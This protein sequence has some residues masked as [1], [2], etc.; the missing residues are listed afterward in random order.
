[1][2]TGNWGDFVNGVSAKVN[3]IIDETE[4]LTPS[5][6][7]SG[8]FDVVSNPDAQI[9][10]TEGVT[11]L[12]YLQQFDEGDQ[13]KEDRTYQSYKTEY[14]MKQYGSKV[15]ISQMLAK[16][17]PADLEAKLNE[18]RQLMIASQRSLKKHAWQVIANGFSTTDTFGDLPISRLSDA[19]SMFSTAH[20]SQVTGVANRS[21][22]VASNAV[23]S[24]S[25]QYTAIKQIREQLN[26]RG[27]EIGYEEDFCVVLPPALEKLGVEI[28]KSMKR[29]GTANND[30]NYYEGIVDV[31]SSTYL[32]NASNG[33]ANADTSWFVFA[34]NPP[35]KMMKY[36][37][38]IDPKIEQTVD[39]DTKSIRVSVDGAWA[40][41]YS[42][43]EFSCGSDGS[44]A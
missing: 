7:E 8:L 21:N 26:D 2:V 31:V 29:Q 44:A 19:V 17:R 30:L 24:E 4:D 10:R 28:N 36:V 18:V 40:M 1:M 37:S 35:H 27:V 41:G 9:Y 13:I 12:S 6:V 39:F 25:N 11:G 43:W 3:E 32:G 34:K 15:A 16:T 5:F 20:P 38:L 23:Y 22:R 42:N 33:I 14:S